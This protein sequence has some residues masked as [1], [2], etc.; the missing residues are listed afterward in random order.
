MIDGQG[1]LIR[2]LRLSVTDRCNLSCVYCRSAACGEPVPRED[3]LS[4]EEIVRVVQIACELGIDRVRITGGE[5]LV[6]QG[7]AKLIR[8]L[9]ES[10]DIA[11]L[12]LSTNGI[13]LASLASE[14]RRAG[15]DRVNVSL[16]SLK[17]ALFRWIT[18]GG[19]LDD[20]LAGIERAQEVGLGPVKVNTVVMKGIND[21][22]VVELAHFALER[23]LT[24]RFI[25]LMP[26]GEAITSGLWRSAYLSVSEVQ[27]RLAM[28]LPLLPAEPTQGGG[29][30]QYFRV[31]GSQGAIGFIAPLS[32]P[33]C[34]H[35]NRIRLTATGELRPCLAHDEGLSLREPLRRGDLERVRELLVR[36]IREKPQ[37]HGW[38][39][40]QPTTTTM[41]DLGG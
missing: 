24:I 20:V 29:P 18:R 1:R 14:L 3:I 6:R 15:L 34:A 39:Q 13:R 16:D 38:K 32:A 7:V 35:C 25:E 30:A 12:S 21:D 37:G 26:I 17:P 11:D 40:D 31:E 9:R 8:M 10:C 4:F 27:R 22:E 23:G 28:E 36:A 2:Y 19:N 33:F 5:P 41:A